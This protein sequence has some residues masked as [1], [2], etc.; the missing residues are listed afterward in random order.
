MVT[1]G[2][3]FVGWQVLI[4]IAFAVLA[5]VGA[6]FG[7]LAAKKRREALAAQAR[8]LGLTFHPGRDTGHDEAYAHFELFARGF[9]R[10][11]YN[12]MWGSVDIGTYHVEC[13]MGD[14]TYKTREGSGKNRR[15]VTHRFS[16]MI[17]HLPW[18]GMPD[19]LIRKEGFFDKI[20]SA[21]GFDDIDFESAEFS[22]AYCVKSANR[23]FAYD[24][25]HPRMIEFLMETGPSSVD[26]ERGRLCMTDG[27]RVWKPEAFGFTVSW[28]KGFLERWP[29]FVVKDL[30]EGRIA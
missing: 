25:C 30:N 16:Y 12:T 24:V 20:G 10:A 2:D 8:A 15:T 29:D 1:I 3:S 28:A 18:G 21:F 14:F 27:S 7:H 22:R 23:K 6:Y 26:I 19:L 17:L 11:A 5:G 4:F 13:K 9:G